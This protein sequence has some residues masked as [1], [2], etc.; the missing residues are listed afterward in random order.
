[1]I[2]SGY[3]VAMTRTESVDISFQDRE[4]V[5]EKMRKRAAEN[6]YKLDNI[7]I[8]C[9][10]GEGIRLQGPGCSNMDPVFMCDLGTVS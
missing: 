9:C 4:N 2:L 7:K 10:Q 3:A 6:F 8:V 5:L 1:M